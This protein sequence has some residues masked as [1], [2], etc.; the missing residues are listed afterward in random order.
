MKDPNGHQLAHREIP[1][2]IRFFN[3]S[4]QEIQNLIDHNSSADDGND[5]FYP[6]VC[7]HLGETKVI[8]LENDGTQMISTIFDSKS[9]RALFNVSDSFREGKNINKRRKWQAPP[10]VVEAEVHEIFNLEIESDSEIS[11]N[12]AS[13]ENLALNQEIEDSQKTILYSTPC[14]FF[15]HEQNKTLKLTT[16]TLDCD[17]VLVNQENDSVWKTVRSWISKVKL[18]TKDVQ[19]QQCKSLLGYANRFEKLFL[20]KETQLVCQK[21]KHSFEQIC[22]PQN[23][24]IGAFNAAH[25]HR[26]SV[27][28]KTLLSLKRFFCWPGMYKSVRTLRKSCLTC[29]RNKQIRKDQNTAPNERWG[30][31]VP[32]PFQTVHTDHKGPLNP[33][34]DGKHLCLVVIDAF[35][36]FIQVY[37]V[38]STDATHTIE[39][40]STFITS[41][42]IPQKLV[43]DRGTSFMS[44]DFSTFLLEFGITHAR[45]TKWSPWTNGKV[46]IQKKHS[47]RY[48]RC[49]LSEAGNNWA[50]LACQFAFAHNTSVN[51]STGKTP[52][53]VLFGFKP[54]I[55]FL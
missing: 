51:S 45:G 22:S 52:Y 3:Q 25:D 7:T 6:I 28:E 30:E 46:E 12:E 32:Y 1:K 50:K 55:P 49:Y 35:S 17:E 19:S 42:G 5:D 54:Q 13:D 14:I 10:M 40:M 24:F 44:T 26:L 21:S 48:F 27:S 31:E 36:R 16:D 15:V 29:R 39:A 4:G 41:F 8:H 47:S 11:D 37:P 2:D 34:S 33:M 20:E 23:C 43:Y 9:A 53:E 18:P 38:K